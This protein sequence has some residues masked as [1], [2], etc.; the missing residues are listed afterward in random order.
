MTAA[1][2]VASNGGRP[3][4]HLIGHRPE[5]V[6]V[7]PVI[8]LALSANLFR[9]HVRRRPDH[10]HR[11]RHRALSG[12][13]G[14]ER[15][16][17]P[18]IGEVGVRSGE[19]DVV[20]LDVAVDHALRVRV[21]QPIS[22]FTQNLHGFADRQRTRP[23]N[24]SAERFAFDVRHDVEEGVGGGTRIEE[25]KDVRMLEVRGRADFLHEAFTADGGDDGR[26]HD[27]ERDLPIV[28]EIARQVDRRHAARAQ[29]A[30]DAVSAG[31]RSGQLLQ[32][33]G[34]LARAE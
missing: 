16:G 32:N 6:D 31:Q 28:P 5:R 29:L 24:A 17:N 30:L 18:K 9:R 27:F 14:L 21:G 13:G 7:R 8:E 23:A 25:R 34:H 2:V 33:R 19:Q 3:G 12:F 20:G 22:H 4:K 15:A 26:V 1:A 10:R 11:R